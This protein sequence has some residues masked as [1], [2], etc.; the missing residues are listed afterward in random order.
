MEKMNTGEQLERAL[1]VLERLARGYE[2]TSL[3]YRALELAG[4]ALIFSY[5]EQVIEKFKQFLK[6]CDSGLTEEQKAFIRAMGIRLNEQ[7][8]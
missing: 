1:E 5:H 8:Q 3:E 6:E 7:G 2:E 4:K